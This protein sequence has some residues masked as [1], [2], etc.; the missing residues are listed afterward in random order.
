MPIPASTSSSPTPRPSRFKSPP[1]EVYPYIDITHSDFRGDVLSQ[2]LFAVQSTLGPAPGYSGN[3]FVVPPTATISGSLGF[4][5]SYTH[6]VS[7][8]PINTSAYWS[9]RTMY[10]VVGKKAAVV[11]SSLNCFT[12]IAWEN[13]SLGS[14][15]DCAEGAGVEAAKAIG[16]VLVFL[17]SGHT[18]KDAMAAV[19]ARLGWGGPID[20]E[21]HFHRHHAPAPPPAGGGHGS[22]TNPAGG[23]D[24]TILVDG[25]I[26]IP[27]DVYGHGTHSGT[28][29]V[30][31]DGSGVAYGMNLA[32]ESDYDT[33][34][35]FARRYPMRSY[36]PLAKLEA[37][38]HRQES[39]YPAECND[40]VPIRHVAANA[41][42]FILR[43]KTGTAWFVDAD[44]NLHWIASGGTFICLAQRYYVL[45]HTPWAEI[46]QFEDAVYAGDATCG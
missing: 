31:L 3:P 15:V 18:L 13:V 4:F 33:Y 14:L 17:D 23:P 25:G 10:E 30:A 7:Y 22:G 36:L 37:Y 29:Y 2:A 5:G 6:Y 26:G 44:S 34:D 46:S 42:N 40:T 28:V 20:G 32:D 38:G 12:A 27:H 9:T 19:K 43:E 21:W 1:D 16:R 39:I 41:T 8:D 11:L 35:C 45:D 24:G